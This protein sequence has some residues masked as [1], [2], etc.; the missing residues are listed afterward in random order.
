MF[1]FIMSPDKAKNGEFGIQKIANYRIFSASNRSIFNTLFNI[2]L[3]FL[4]LTD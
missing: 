3:R 1:L 2:C 4:N